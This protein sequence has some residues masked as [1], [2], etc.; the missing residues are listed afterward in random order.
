MKL[1]KVGFVCLILRVQTR[2]MSS[3]PRVQL[4]FAFVQRAARPCET[5]HSLYKSKRCGSPQ[6]GLT[7]GIISV[8]CIQQARLS[9]AHAVFGLSMTN[10]RFDGFGDILIVRNGHFCEYLPS[11]EPLMHQQIHIRGLVPCLACMRCRQADAP[12]ILCF[13]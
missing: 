12:S 1:P 13:N 3:R 11:D 9:R 2:S 5:T 4:Y 8:N 7:N 10:G 6:C